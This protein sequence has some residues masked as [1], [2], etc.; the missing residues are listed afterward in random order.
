MGLIVANHRST[1]QI[2]ENFQ[3]KALWL[4]GLDKSDRL[5]VIEVNPIYRKRGEKDGKRTYE[6]KS[7]N[8]AKALLNLE[9][10]E[11]RS[12]L[13]KKMIE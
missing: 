6:W 11:I 8:D 1:S 4:L 7:S 3:Q 12:F 2:V 9:P 13:I 5:E 10:F